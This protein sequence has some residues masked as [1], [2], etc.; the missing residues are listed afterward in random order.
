MYLEWALNCGRIEP[1]RLG[2]ILAGAGQNAFDT[3]DEPEEFDCPI[4]LLIALRYEPDDELGAQYNFWTEVQGPNG[5]KLREGFSYEFPFTNVNYLRN[6]ERE[7][8]SLNI[9]LAISS[10]GVYRIVF[11]DDVTD[12]Y[13]MELIFGDAPPH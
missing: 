6:V 5:P 1:D 7:Y 12:R 9:M 13:Q 11:G 4:S 3:T 8:Q 2:F 10:R